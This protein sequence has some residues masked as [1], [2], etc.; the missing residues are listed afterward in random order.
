[1]RKF[2]WL[3]K[4]DYKALKK[5]DSQNK[6]EPKTIEKSD[7]PIRMYLREM[8]GVELFKRR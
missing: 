6:E 1:M 3:K 8:G 7:D 4:I 5:R 2:R